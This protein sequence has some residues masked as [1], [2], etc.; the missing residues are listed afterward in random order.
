MTVTLDEVL[1]AIAVAALQRPAPPKNERLRPPAPCGTR[2]DGVRAGA[3]GRLLSGTP[4]ARRRWMS[5]AWEVDVDCVARL[6]CVDA[7]LWM[8]LVRGVFGFI[9]K[10][11][12]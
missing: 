4:V 1:F 10:M 6:A 7:P 9:L 2:R 12:V 8:S 3:A 5:I 11:V